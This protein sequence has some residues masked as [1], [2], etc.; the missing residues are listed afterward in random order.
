MSDFQRNREGEK[1]GFGGMKL[2]SSPDSLHPGKYPLAIN[3]RAYS[4]D[5]LRTRPG[6]TL[7]TT[8]TGASAAITDLRAYTALLTD[9]LPRILAR[10]TGDKVWLD[11]GATVG[12]LAGG[13]A[14][15]GATLI[16][17]RPNASPTP[18]MY[19]ANGSDYQKFSAP[20]G[21]NVVNMLKVGIAEPQISPEAG[22][23]NT[24]QS[25]VSGPIGYNN[26]GTA[27]A[28]SNSARVSDTVGVV[29]A[30]PAVGGGANAPY[31]IQVAT[32]V[33]YQR[34][35]TVTINGHFALVTDVFPSLPVAL[36]LSGIFYFTGTTG[37]CVLAINTLTG[38]GGNDSIY[39]PLLLASLRRGA[40]IKI[41][42]EYVLVLSVSVG[43]DGSFAVETSTT[44]TH[45]IADT[46]TII[47]A[48]QVIELI[49]APAPGNAIADPATPK[50]YAVTAGV[51]T[52]TTS[53]GLVN[54][55]VS[56]GGGPGAIF[57]END[58]IS[59]GFRV[60]I[61]SNVTEFKLLFD[62]DDGS[63]TKNFY[64]YT[65]RASD[66]ASAIANAVT[67][68]AIAQTVTQRALVDEENAISSGNQ[69]TTFSGAQA[70]TGAN[71]WGQIVFS[72]RELTRVG[73]DETK[74]LLTFTAFQVLWNV[75]GNVTVVQDNFFTVFG[76]FQPDV[77]DVGAPYLYRVRP[78]SKITGAVGNPS[79]ATRYGVSPRRQSVVI[80]LPSAAYDAQID[81]WDIER[82]GGTVTSWRY[83]GSTTSSASFFTDNFDDSAVGAGDALEFDNF[84]PWP[85]VDVPNNGTVSIV[86]G[87]VAIASSA[88]TDMAKY[89][90]GTL[91]QL[92]GLNVYTL[93]ARPVFITGTTY[94]LEFLENA[95]VGASVSYN[96]QEPL[97][98][99]KML[100]YMWGPDV[101]GTVF[102]VGDPLNPG[103][104]Y[105]SKNNAP[106]SAPDS[107]N[108][109]I[110][111]PSEP[112][113][114]GQVVD[115]LSLVG[116]SERWWAL[117]PQPDNPAQ[118]YNYVEQP[119]T[120]GIAAPYG[121][122]TDG[123]QIFFWAKDGIY[124]TSQGSLTDDDLYNLFPHE[125]VP[126]VNVIYNLITIYAPDYAK[127]AKFRLEYSNGYLY[128][129]YIGASDGFYHTLT[130]DLRR[131]AWSEDRWGG[132]GETAAVL[133]SAAYHVEQPPASS[134]VRNSV[135]L[136]AGRS[137]GGGSKG[138]IYAQADITNDNVTPITSYLATREFDGGDI[139]A[140]KQWGDFFLDC[141]PVSSLNVTPM[142]LGASA[143][144]AITIPTSAT[145]VR[146]P[147]SAGG[148]VV[149]DF[150]GLFILW[151]DDF[152]IKTSP[153]QLIAWQLSYDIQPA[154]TIG[155]TTFGASFGLQGFGHIQQIAIAWVS[156]AA[157]TLTITTFDGQSPQAITIPSSGGAYKKQLFP[158]TANKGQLFVFAAASSAPFQIF[159][160]DCELHIG[161]WSRNEPYK[162]FKSFGGA[163]ISGAVI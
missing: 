96:I 29:F 117:Y 6:L 156:T 15:P 109:E 62:V 39:N 30:D 46:I 139:R 47:P 43:P 21:S 71:Q 19:V 38:Q 95:G 85:V 51:G 16:P 154:R 37:R 125:G 132:G 74:S 126:G 56:P 107:Y 153:T 69:G 70:A 102:A 87:T 5:S 13:G 90:P 54:L 49:A 144:G 4:G 138:T 52:E 158:L 34:M 77:G 55:F 123:K 131:M 163:E 112:L 116:S 134:G 84:E 14:S 72:I 98:A 119:V 93:R 110:T 65:V 1:F 79:P 124:G 22:I 91:V 155:W 18:Y 104:L 159:S 92:G 150:M 17:F 157:I 148:L 23:V 111:Q 27:G 147:V 41:A 28:A 113:L 101:N 137:G 32:T 8:T 44:S 83:V 57:Q 118:R 146:S 161:A 53:N 7:L 3:V 86:N 130:L 12:T 64:Y 45:T 149:S 89:L 103:K 78:R 76:G 67:Q 50:T 151:T 10:D 48:I 162:I 68:L 66:I 88:D 115:G 36:T 11:N 100:P 160:D 122:C 142:S 99:N 135:L 129:I 141:V 40:I 121:H 35:M 106:D 80:D 63:F 114:G 152:S 133:I 20:D 140:P 127:A 105:F 25:N 136:F 58:Y 60:D 73:S 97:I 108:I 145:R 2:N 81:T 31:S 120:R 59:M 128:A 42:A 61:P 75:S 26:A 82:Y 24:V 33:A 143:V 9:S 94:R